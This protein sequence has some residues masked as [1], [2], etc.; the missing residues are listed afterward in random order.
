MQ[1]LE[2]DAFEIGYGMTAGMLPASRADQDAAFQRMNSANWGTAVKTGT[3]ASDATEK[4]VSFSST[5]ARYVRF[6]AL[7]EIAGK[8]YAAVAEL[9]VV[10]TAQ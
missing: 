5:T 6:R 9:N 4:V 8:A 1:G 7:S 10:G 2:A 3:F